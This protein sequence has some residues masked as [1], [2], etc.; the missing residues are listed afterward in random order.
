MRSWFICCRELRVLDC[1]VRGL[2]QATQPGSRAGGQ[3]D[4][5]IAVFVIAQVR[6]N[7]ASVS[8]VQYRNRRT[9]DSAACAA[10][11]GVELVRPV[12]RLQHD[13][14]QVLDILSVNR[15]RKG[16]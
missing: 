8:Q 16:V 9:G 11:R 3:V 10:G 12:A 6:E 2:Q 4:A 7:P 14:P 13:G 15:W 1:R 5:L